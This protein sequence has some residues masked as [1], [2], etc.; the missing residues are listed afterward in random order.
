M[1]TILALVARRFSK[2]LVLA[3]AGG[4]FTGALVLSLL[5]ANH[6]RGACSPLG[7]AGFVVC[8]VI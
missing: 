1:L 6:L 5:L 8:K 4:V 3:F 2:R 7:V